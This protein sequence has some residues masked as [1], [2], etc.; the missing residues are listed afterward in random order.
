VAT[1]PIVIA[2]QGDDSQLSKTL[3]SA[4]GKV[5]GFGKSVAKVGVMAGAA[6]GGAAVAIG[7][8]GVK[9]FAEFDTQMR[10]VLTLLPGAGDE[11]FD[12]LGDQVK[13]FSKKFGVLPNE[14]IPALYSALSA[15]VPE[16]S[17]FDFMETAQKA[18]KGGVTDLATAVDGLSTVLN[19]YPEGALTAAEASDAMFTAVKLGKTTMEE[20]SASMFNVAPIGA[21]LGVNFKGITAALANLTAAGTPTSVAASQMKAALSELG[22]SGTKASDAF[23]EFTG[24]G[25][26]QF[27]EQEGNLAGAFAKMKEAADASGVSVLDLFGSIE[28]GQAVLSLTSDGGEAFQETLTEMHQSAGATDRAFETMNSGM[29]A[30]FDRIKANLSVLAIEIG[31]K[32]APVVEKATVLILKGFENLKPVIKTVQKAVVGFAKQAKQFVLPILQSI[33][34]WVREAADDVRNFLTPVFRAVARAAEFVAEKFME[35]YRAAANYLTPGLEALWENIVRAKDALVALVQD[36]IDWVV[37][38]FKATNW[39]QLGESIAAAFEKVRAAVMEFVRGIPD[40]FRTAIDWVQKYRKW[41]V[42]LGGAV[43]AGVV[44]FKAYKT[45]LVLIDKWNKI[46]AISTKLWNAAMA[47]NPVG[48]VVAAVVLLVGALA[49]AYTQF[50]GVRRVV[51]ATAVF[52]RDNI[53]P[54]FKAFWDTLVARIKIFWTAVK[55]LVGLVQ[56]IFTGDWADVWHHAKQ[57]VVTALTAVVELMIGLPVRIIEAVKPLALKLLKWLGDVFLDLTDALI[58]ELTK[59]VDFWIKLPGRIIDAVADMGSK[60]V[61]WINDAT[62]DMFGALKSWVID[63]FLEFFKKLPGRII[64]AVKGMGDKLVTWI[65]DATGDMFGALKSWVTD[66]FLEFF[67]KLPGRVI[68]MLSAM[69][70]RF[71]TWIEGSVGRLLTAVS[72]WVTNTL[73]P[74]FKNLPGRIVGAASLIYTKMTDLG[75]SIGTKVFDGLKTVITSA[76]EFTVRMKDAI[77]GFGGDVVGWIVDGIK[78]AAGSIWDA[79]KGAL[80]DNIPDWVPGWLNPFDGDGNGKSLS[81]HATK[82]TSSLRHVTAMTGAYYENGVLVRAARPL[83]EVLAERAAAATSPMPDM[84]GL[85]GGVMSTLDLSPG[86]LDWFENPETIIAFRKAG[87]LDDFRRFKSEGDLA[88]MEKFAQQGYTQIDINVE[89]GLGTD[90]VQVGNDIVSALRQWERA[91]GSVPIT[92]GSV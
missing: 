37:K 45:V 12:R 4:A 25:L 59:T 17:V 57:L 34:E 9:A 91:N 35:A 63:D 42:T 21:A 13:S 10:E 43:A 3:R 36:G 33:V 16:G 88:G 15:G 75:K 50:E 14:T 41:I 69:G 70:G 74:F 20:L 77:V 28:A 22:K 68:A 26:Q 62:G 55:E 46:V 47:A 89:A 81:S 90:G 84:T 1:K 23:Q 30:S 64:N 67:K 71:V 11:A 7:T 8:Q 78:A 27:L 66:D 49:A 82:Q 5:E 80:K 19:S 39:G 40:G 65:T 58:D 44:A 52:F 79:L 53:L 54:I 92:V 85:Q 2:I 56:A 51:N 87:K 48:L 60:L 61:T 86:S 29:A 6:F 76:Y 83:G 38:K 72:D 32:L 31:E 18:A 24:M 73:L